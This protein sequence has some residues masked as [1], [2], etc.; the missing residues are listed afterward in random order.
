MITDRLEEQRVDPSK[1]GFIGHLHAF[2]GFAIAAIVAA[3]CWSFLLFMGPYETMPAHTSVYA[4]VETLF[5]DSTIFFALISG[6]LFSLVLKDK[7]WKKFFSSKLKHVVAPYAFVNLM[8]IGAFWPMYAEYLASQE[9]STNFLVAYLQG[10]VSGSLMLPFW[11][12]PVLIALYV[13]TP[14]F[15]YLVWS[16]RFAWVAWMLALAPLVVSRSLFPVLISGPTLVYFAGTYVLGMLIGKHYSAA[17]DL[18]GRYLRVIWVAAIGCSMAIWLQYVN[19][20]EAE[21]WFSIRESLFYVQKNAMA[22]LAIHYF[23]RSEAV[24]PK[25]LFTFGTY[26]FAIYFLHFFFINISAQLVF[27][28]TENNAN[29]ATAAAGGAFIMAVSLSLSLLIA[30]LLKKAF[31]R[32]S[33]ML[34]GV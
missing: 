2:R 28:A 5:H 3:H 32:Y 18:I 11:Y 26:A 14:A 34:I 4:V 9:Q 1:P 33:R 30:W 20:F 12:I 13:L 16:R 19:E 31:R 8:F 7:G 27:L 24:L 10:L 6:L 23:A 21:G 25:W 22:A 29:A 17:L 15:S